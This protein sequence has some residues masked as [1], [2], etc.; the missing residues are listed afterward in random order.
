MGTELAYGPPA[1]QVRAFQEVLGEDADLS[2]IRWDLVLP[3]AQFL[4]QLR[5]VL[6]SSQELLKNSDEW[7]YLAT[8]QRTQEAYCGLE[9]IT[10]D[11]TQLGVYL[12][13]CRDGRRDELESFRGARPIRY[14]RQTSTGRLT[15][16]EGPRVLTLDKQYRDILASRYGAEGRVIQLDY[17]SLEPRVLLALTGKDA[18]DDVYSILE[19]RIPGLERSEYK[20]A[21][22]TVLY[23]GGIPRLTTLLG[24]K[25]DPTHVMDQIRDAFGLR[26]LEDQLRREYEITGM[27]TNFY[28]R[29]LKPKRSH[30][31]YLVAAYVQST[32]VDVALQGFRQIQQIAASLSGVHPI[33]IVHDALWLDVHLDAAEYNSRLS[34]AGEK[35]PGLDMRFP[36]SQEN[37]NG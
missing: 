26:V 16:L 18:P 10:L 14:S 2:A 7:K 33:A 21:M 8:F 31:G 25:A 32:A 20:V 19:E 24:K 34:E 9:K 13:T 15:V 29:V 3:K 17:V 37:I 12:Q 6:R 11:R 35:V 5:T 27:L 1:Q 23:G 28:G 4:E 36:L 30:P 22:M